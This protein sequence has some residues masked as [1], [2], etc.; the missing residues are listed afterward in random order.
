MVT[1]S[2][3]NFGG[4][5]EAVT[6]SAWCSPAS[7]SSPID[8]QL[9]FTATRCNV[10][11]DHTEVQ[12]L[13]PEAVGATLSWRISVDGLVSSVPAST[14]AGPVILSVEIASPTLP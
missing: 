4:V 5:G 13:M 7:L 3:L 2:G 8:S 10:T 6:I 12:C 11:G 14:L 1:L 9:V